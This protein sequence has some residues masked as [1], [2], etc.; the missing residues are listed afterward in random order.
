M[1]KKSKGM[2]SPLSLIDVGVKC[3]FDDFKKMA[4]RLTGSIRKRYAIALT[5][6]AKSGRDA[7]REAFDENYTV[8][9]QYMLKG[10]VHWPA[11]ESKLTARVGTVNYLMALHL[12]GGEKTGPVAMEGIRGT[13]RK[14]GKATRTTKLSNL[15][16]NF[17]DKPTRSSKVY[18]MMKLNGQTYIMK[19]TGDPVDRQRVRKGKIKSSQVLPRG[20]LIP[21]WNLREGDKSTIKPDWRIASVIQKD[22]DEKAA[23]IMLGVLEDAWDHEVK[24]GRLDGAN[25]FKS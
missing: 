9:S 4:G 10:I 1:G 16:K 6:L 11:S 14:E 18:F 25:P 21:M 24:Q 23:P 22:L 7:A 5:L 19:K 8:R 15:Q 20:P 12:G 13:G 2:A 3:D 17:I